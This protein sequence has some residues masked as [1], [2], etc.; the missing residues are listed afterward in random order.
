MNPSEFFQQ[1]AATD[2][3][4]PTGRPLRVAHL[5]VGLAR[6]G[7][8][9]ALLL[10]ILDARAV[11]VHVGKPGCEAAQSGADIALERS[12]LIYHAGE[13]LDAQPWLAA[14]D[15]CT[16]SGTQHAWL[17]SLRNPETSSIEASE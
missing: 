6:A 9:T 3:E 10:L 11:F 12:P 8:E 5:V 13:Q 2:G 4:Q 1:C 14:A 16:M 17:G 15:V 7:A